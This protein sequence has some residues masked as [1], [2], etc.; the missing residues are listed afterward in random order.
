MSDFKDRLITE[1]SELDEKHTKLYTFLGSEES[2]KID[3][4]QLSLLNIQLQAMA[5]Y[6]L[7]LAE[8]IAWLNQNK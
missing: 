3:P 6:S 4:V 2:K 8:R 5:T 7:C 1:K